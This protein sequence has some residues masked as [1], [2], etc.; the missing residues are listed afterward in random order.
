MSAASDTLH[1]RF[2]YPRAFR[3]LI[4]DARFKGVHGGRGSAKS[5]FYAS[6]LVKAMALDPDLRCVG[7]R[8]V[9]KSL[10][11][12]SK[13]LIEDKITEHGLEALFEPQHDVIKRR[14]GSGLCIFHGMRGQTAESI[15]SL[16]GFRIG[17][18]DEAQKMSQ[19]SLDLLTPTF[20][21]GAQLWF[22]WNRERRD[23]PVEQLFYGEPPH[24]EAVVV[25]VR[26]EDN[27]WLPD[28]LR[29]EME[30]MR[31]RDPKKYAHVYGGGFL[32]LDDAQVFRNW[33]VEEFETPKKAV[34]YL[35]AD[36]GFSIDPTVLIRCFCD[37]EARKLYVDR[38]A[39]QVGCPID[40][41]PALFDGL[42][43][44]RPRM[45]REWTITADSARPETI[46]HLKRH[47]FP[48][49]VA[50]AKG[51]G[52]V[53]EGIEFL[54]GWDIVVH[55]RCTHAIDE[56]TF[57]SFKRDPHTDQ[58][59]PILEDKK[60]HVIDALRYAVEPMRRKRKRVGTW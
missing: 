22:S 20:R 33:T 29:A 45:A 5:H 36:W 32:E 41:V 57:Y 9:Q 6:R 52:S 1:V 31:R 15:K 16:E 51:A 10:A 43:P 8:E 50:S 19:R 25:E 47:G 39:Y 54:R 17:W 14:H 46:D 7:L 4:P 34:F 30:W 42:D 11:M 56:L 28:D 58:V 49:M 40:H 24:P 37:H 60:N 26:P 27:P 59:I 3:P 12:S 53:Q 55:P 21:G 18:F 48:R 38:E 13:L 2:P 44:E 35:G 23:D